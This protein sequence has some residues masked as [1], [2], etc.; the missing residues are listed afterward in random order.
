MNGENRFAL[1]PEVIKNLLIINGLFYLAT[2]S[3]GLYG[4]DLTRNLGLY[5]PGSEHFRPYQLVTHMFMHGGL[6]HLFLNMLSLWMFGLAMENYW[7]AKRFLTYYLVTGLGAA[8][9]HLGVSW[10]EALNYRNQLLDAG[11]SASDLDLL[12]RT[13]QYL[14]S[15]LSMQ[16]ARLLQDYASKYAYPTVGASGAVFGVLLAFGMSFPDQRIYLYF[17]IPV[18]AK[19]FVIGYGLVELW[20]GLSM[21]RGSNIAH[22]AHLGGMLF[23]WILIRFWRSRGYIR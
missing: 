16:Y 1:L 18:K 20:N 10:I 12:A 3:L 7:G 8:L 22:F 14:N 5:L 11:F 4:I 2:L 13:G 15:E 21:D 9:L 17:A 19:Y 6:L 23:G